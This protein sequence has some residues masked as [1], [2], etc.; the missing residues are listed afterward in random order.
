MQPFHFKRN[1]VQYCLIDTP[2]FD[3]TYENQD[4]TLKVILSWLDQAL[5]S[6]VRLNGVVY[7]HSIKTPRLH[8]SAL[9]H[10]R[11]FR[12][13]VGDSNFYN[14][15]LV[16]SF[17]DLEDR[18]VAEAREEELQ[19]GCWSKLC[20]KGATVF[21]VHYGK[22]DIS[23]IIH[24]ISQG[25]KTILGIQEQMA[26]NK[27]P[28]V[29]A[30][31]KG[32]AMLEVVDLKKLE[33]E[34][35]REIDKAR[36]EA[37]ELT[38]QNNIELRKNLNREKEEINKQLNM[39]A[40][41]YELQQGQL[42]KEEQR[43]RKNMRNKRAELQRQLESGAVDLD[44]AL[45]IRSESSVPGHMTPYTGPVQYIASAPLPAPEKKGLRYSLKKW[46]KNL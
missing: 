26:T 18:R 27:Q 14:V 9:E 42:R 1:G 12:K 46:I 25:N 31:E 29:A 37:R 30:V 34:H 2:G 8:G 15:A 6:G 36:K 16:T 19:N 13:I 4:D 24:H 40:R 33:E 3:D 41:T 43:L 7:L 23:H 20:D 44:D 21:R 28:D 38:K 32:L 39:S 35:A 5:K 10:L 17:W 11:T 22:S 45:S